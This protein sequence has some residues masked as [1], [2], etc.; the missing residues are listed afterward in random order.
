MIYEDE[1]YAIN[2]AMIE[3]S[4]QLGSGFLEKVYQEALMIE[5]Q[6]KNV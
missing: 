4:K 1:S 5:F 3:V 2:G 6:C